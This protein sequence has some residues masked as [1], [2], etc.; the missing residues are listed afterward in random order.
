[1]TQKTRPAGD[2]LVAESLLAV[3]KTNGHVSLTGKPGAFT[4]PDCEFESRRV[5]SKGNEYHLPQRK[6]MIFS[7]NRSAKAPNA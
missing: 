2:N 1:M 7:P 3:G 6:A 4:S 5:H